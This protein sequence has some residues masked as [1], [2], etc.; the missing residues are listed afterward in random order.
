MISISYTPRNSVY[1]FAVS[2][3]P[4]TSLQNY[5]GFASSTFASSGVLFLTAS[6]LLSAATNWA[7]S[8]LHVMT[9]SESARPSV[10]RSM[11]GCAVIQTTNGASFYRNATLSTDG[12]V[13]I[14]TTGVDGVTACRF[15]GAP[16]RL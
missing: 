13:T 10:S 12:R 4:R 5:S 9:V 16:V 2:V 3:T 15:M 7:S 1:Q 6:V 14:D 8:A 11:P